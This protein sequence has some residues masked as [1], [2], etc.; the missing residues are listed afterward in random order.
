MTWAIALNYRIREINVNSN[1][2]KIMN[3]IEMTSVSS[4][5]KRTSINLHK[6]CEDVISCLVMIIIRQDLV[7]RIDVSSDLMQVLN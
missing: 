1:T 5:M 3:D 4:V 2:H 6:T 7:N